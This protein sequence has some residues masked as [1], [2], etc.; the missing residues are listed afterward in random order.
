MLGQ[1]FLHG[2]AA[3]AFPPF[4]SLF[5]KLQGQPR[6]SRDRL[7]AQRGLIKRHQAVNFFTGKILV[8]NGHGHIQQVLHVCL[9]RELFE[10]KIHQFFAIV[11]GGQRVCEKR[12]DRLA[13]RI[14]GLH[15]QV[16]GADKVEKTADVSLL[17]GID[18]LIA[19]GR[20][21]S[22]GLFRTWTLSPGSADRRGLC[23]HAHR[24]DQREGCHREKE[25]HVFPPC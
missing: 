13:H 22:C 2:F 21:G 24:T 19:G 20:R 6:K 4:S 23:A 12:L 18:L 14:H 15:H 9:R 10:E 5:L 8:I 3:Q 11:S 17:G 7:L 25:L 16:P 1:H